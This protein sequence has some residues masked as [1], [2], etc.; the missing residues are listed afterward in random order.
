MN[1]YFWNP[2]RIQ[3]PSIKSAL[4][5]LFSK[6]HASILG[7]LETKKSISDSYL[8]PLLQQDF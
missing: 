2:R 3:A 8:N 7:F 4:I 5:D 1:I 6:T